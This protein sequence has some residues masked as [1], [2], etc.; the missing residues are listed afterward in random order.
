MACV[1]LAPVEREVVRCYSCLLNQFMPQNKHCRKCRVYLGP[2]VEAPA[3]ELV[4]T[5][6]V[7]DNPRHYL[8][9]VPVFRMDLAI[10]ILRHRLNL[11]ARQLAERMDKPR[12][13]VSK[14]ENSKC[15]PTLLSIS[16]F[17]AALEVT[18][19]QLVDLATV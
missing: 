7:D 10:F 8:Y 3:L 4:P 6:V 15:Q 11:S 2:K 16:Q 14:V 18:P 13:Y 1:A 9:G 17:A 19:Y 5:P 12:T